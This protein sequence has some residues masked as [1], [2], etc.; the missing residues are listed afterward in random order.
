MTGALAI[1]AVSAVLRD[2]LDNGMVDAPQV[3]PV[4]VTA[5]APD[6]I[7]LDGPQADRRL[8]L[9]LY[10]VT[11]N[12]GWR[13]AALPAYSTNGTRL[14]N[15]PLGLDLHFLLTAYADADFEAEILLGYAMQILHERPVLDRE[16][17]RTSLN[18]TPLGGSILPPAYL[19]VSASELANQ[20]EPVTVTLEPMDTEEM[21]KLWSAIQSHYRP[22]AA[23]V[24]SVVLIESTRPSRAALPV[25]SRGPVDTATE[26]ERGP[27]VEPTLLPPLPTLTGVVRKDHERQPA[28]RLGE[29]LVLQGHHLDGTSMVVTFDHP[30]RDTPTTIPVGAN[31]TPASVEVVLP[32]GNAADAAW[33]AGIWSVSVDVVR[34]GETVVRTSNVAAMMLAPEPVLAPPPTMTRTGAGDLTMTLRVHPDVRIGQRVTLALGGDVV[35]ADPHPATTDTLTFQ[36]GKVPAGAQWVRLTVDGVES[37]LVDRDGS[38]PTFDPSQSV[39]VPA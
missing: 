1:G 23:Y 32:S 35:P 15:P 13:N 10:R 2:L 25:L 27:T 12:Q 34:P 18:A 38:V 11:P 21:S 37:L 3:G 36:F 7:K 22:S 33:P 5:V 17:I 30:L 14:T 31:P 29:T 8:N 24:A 20:I 39:T 4:K 19:A 6:T 26:L 16:S 28:V 9:F